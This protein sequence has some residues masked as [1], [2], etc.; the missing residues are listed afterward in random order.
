[1]N[2]PSMAKPAAGPGLILCVNS[3]ETTTKKS[4]DEK[5]ITVNFAFTHQLTAVM[6]RSMVR[7]AN[8]ATQSTGAQPARADSAGSFHSTGGRSVDT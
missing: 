5:I 2:D 3:N 7:E 6:L 4:H 1:M 8:A